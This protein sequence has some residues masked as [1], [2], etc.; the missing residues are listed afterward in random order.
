MENG[1]DFLKGPVSMS[2]QEAL[3][4][5]LKINEE[6]FIFLFVGRM[7]WYKNI[8]FILEG[9]TALNQDHYNFKAIFVGEGTDLDAIRQKAQALNLEDHCILQGQSITGMNLEAIIVCQ[10][11][12]YFHHSMIPM[13]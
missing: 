12:F 7:M 13:V 5:K 1:T 2:E 8:E 10:I 11:Y 9:L 6:T 3:K 4:N